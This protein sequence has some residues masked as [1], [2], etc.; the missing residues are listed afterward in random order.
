MRRTKQNQ[1]KVINLAMQSYLKKVSAVRGND[2][3]P[4][5]KTKGL[6]FL[7]SSVG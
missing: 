2:A 6:G 5:R 7:L 3:L 4:G 1:K